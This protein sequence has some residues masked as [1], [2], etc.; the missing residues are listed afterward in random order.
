MT[1]ADPV[2]YQ[3]QELEF[4]NRDCPLNNEKHEVVVLERQKAVEESIGR[5]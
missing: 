5:K 2:F 3:Q 1:F 4:S